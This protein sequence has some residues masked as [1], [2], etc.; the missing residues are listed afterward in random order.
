MATNTKFD[1]N[2][3]VEQRINEIERKKSLKDLLGSAWDVGCNGFGLVNDELVELR[4]ANIVSKEKSK[5]AAIA[6]LME[7]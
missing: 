7:K 3:L 1:M 5:R 2:S 6:A 4:Y